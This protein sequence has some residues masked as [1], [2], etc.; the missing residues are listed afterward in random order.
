MLPVLVVDGSVSVP[1]N[2]SG[3]V[4]FLFFFLF[5]FWRR[6]RCAGLSQLLFTDSCGAQGACRW[7]G[8]KARLGK[9]V[10]V[11]RGFRAEK[12]NKRR[13]SFRRGQEERQEKRE[14]GGK[15]LEEVQRE[16]SHG[17]KDRPRCSARRG[18]KRG[19]REGRSGR[20]RLECRE[21]AR[22]TSRDRDTANKAVQPVKGERIKREKGQKGQKGQ[23]TVDRRCQSDSG[24][25]RHRAG[26]H[27]NGRSAN[28]RGAQKGKKGKKGKKG[29][30]PGAGRSDRRSERQT[31]TTMW[32]VKQRGV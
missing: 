27:E 26:W 3:D 19:G 8:G 6:L 23:K 12:R 18:K 15:R 5:F 9:G 16:K 31:A 21:G 28:G 24:V 20:V 11:R 30:A 17:R 22:Q 32:I 10:A 4:F 25:V 1:N 14:R 13:G 2:L 29:T 7:E